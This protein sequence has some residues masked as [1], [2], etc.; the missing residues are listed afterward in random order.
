VAKI[1]VVDD[2]PLIVSLIAEVAIEFDHTVF[3]ALNGKQALEIYLREL[4][5]LV[6]SDIMMP[7]IDGYE[8]C[9]RI[10]A[11]SS[12]RETKIALMTAGFFDPAAVDGQYDAF[13]KK[14]FN[15]DEV[16]YL[17]QVMLAEHQSRVPHLNQSE[18]TGLSE[19]V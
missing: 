17:L 19:P 12:Q 4:P 10:R 13:L 6:I 2:E 7:G 18:I 15:I 1:L 16:D 5:Q 3:T 9:R 8:V 14:P 11:H